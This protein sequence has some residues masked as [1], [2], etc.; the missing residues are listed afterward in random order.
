MEYKNIDYALYQLPIIG[1]I[2]E[3][4]HRYFRKHMTITDLVHVLVGFGF[5]LIVA[6]DNFMFLGVLALILGAMHHLY[7]FIKG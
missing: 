2:F 7:A 4:M 1:R 6:G 3:R 5:G